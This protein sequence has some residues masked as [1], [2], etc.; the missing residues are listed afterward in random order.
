MVLLL[1]ALGLG[2][3]H[4][5]QP[6]HGKTLVAATMLGGRGTILRG[7]ILAILTTL[8]HTG[9]VL[10]VAGVLWWFESRDFR[11]IHLGLAT[12]PAC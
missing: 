2:A 1:I 10:L 9:S 4:A 6:G 5:F 7:T 8:T 3:V 12:P 11:T